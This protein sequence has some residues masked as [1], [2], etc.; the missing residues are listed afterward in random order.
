[1]SIIL[2]CSLTL[3]LG[4]MPPNSYAFE[5][6]FINIV[7]K[8][9]NGIA[10]TIVTGTPPLYLGLPNK[11]AYTNKL[12]SGWMARSTN[13]ETSFFDWDWLTEKHLSQ[14]SKDGPSRLVT[15]YTPTN[16]LI[17]SDTTVSAQ[18][19]NV[20]PVS[21]NTTY[22]HMLSQNSPLWKLHP[23][24]VYSRTLIE[25]VT[26][27]IQAWLP[28]GDS[29]LYLFDD[30]LKL[31][32]EDNDG[33][34]H[35]SYLSDR[36][37]Y[38]KFTPPKSGTYYFFTTAHTEYSPPFDH[39]MSFFRV[40]TSFIAEPQVSVTWI[41]SESTIAHTRYAPGEKISPIQVPKRKG[42]TF[43]GWYEDSELTNHAE[44]SNLR[45][46][47]SDICFYAKWTSNE[48]HLKGLGN[49]S[50][51]LAEQ[52]KSTN[53]TN[54]LRIHRDT[55]EITIRPLRYISHSRIFIKH[56]G[57]TYKETNALGITLKRGE[58]KTVYIKCVSQTGF[59]YSSIYKIFV[60]R[61]R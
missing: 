18:W 57:G 24:A 35:M 16:V 23:V 50:G 12:F 34:T 5:Q 17:S 52:W 11:P 20:Y 2:S 1:M 54:R 59:C 29:H 55:P 61:N 47:T 60:T 22:Q 38:I 42:F 31:L 9:N 43:A 30:S 45:M 19:V 41:S 27:H 25:G 46:P 7:Y 33:N 58:T 40:G 36:S 26:Y 44:F 8:Y 10:S 32:F 4:I 6:D 39:G 49:S 56:K 3:L 48:S 37:S 53:Y 14:P 13:G 15:Q 51:K 28:G 21:L